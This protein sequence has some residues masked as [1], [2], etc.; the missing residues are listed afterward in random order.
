M[1]VIPS[2]GR[3]SFICSKVL[4]SKR[5]KYINY[6]VI[7]EKNKFTF[8]IDPLQKIKWLFSVT[9]WNF[10]ETILH[11]TYNGNIVHFCNRKHIKNPA[12][13]MRCAMK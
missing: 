3:Q 11:R 13:T 10:R 4:Y 5:D 8:L 6:T 12:N 7:F 2:P 1:K 9:N